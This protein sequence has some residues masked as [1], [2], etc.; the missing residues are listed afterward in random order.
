MLPRETIA[1][2]DAYLAERDLS[3]KAV[4]IGGAALGL[5][6]VVTRQTRDCDILCPPIPPMIRAAARSFA[7]EQRRAGDA[8]ADDWLNDKPSSL[9]DVL[10][11][12][13]GSTY[14]IA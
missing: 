10:P 4:V 8:L 13:E 12:T 6:G 7:E 3:L 9:A 5:L 1:K 14:R 2:F 11:S